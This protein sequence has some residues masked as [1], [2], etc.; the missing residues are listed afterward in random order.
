MFKHLWL[1]NADSPVIPVYVYTLDVLPDP[2][3]YLNCVFMCKHSCPYICTLRCP[4]FQGALYDNNL[5][6]D[7]VILNYK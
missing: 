1:Q 5:H 2:K 4:C 6:F 7:T 3:Q